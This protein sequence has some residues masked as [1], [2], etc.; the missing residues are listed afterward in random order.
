MWRYFVHGLVTS[1]VIS[2]IVRVT[3]LSEASWGVSIGAC[4]AVGVVLGF[5]WLLILRK[6]SRPQE[7]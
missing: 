2:A 3:G 7:S 6:T 5:G 4:I 1:L